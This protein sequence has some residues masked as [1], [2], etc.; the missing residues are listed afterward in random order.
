VRVVLFVLSRGFFCL[1]FSKAEEED[2]VFVIL[3]PLKYTT[4]RL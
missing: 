4:K 1:D 3:D 2:V